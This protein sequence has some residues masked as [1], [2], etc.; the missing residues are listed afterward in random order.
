[1][2]V[3]EGFQDYTVYHYGRYEQGFLDR[4]RRS[5]NENEAAAID[6]IRSRTCNVL[7]VIYSHFYFPTHSNSL[8]D[9]GKLL[10]AVWSA[11]DA[12]GIRSLAWRLAWE[13]GREEALKEQLLVY[14]QEDCLAL[15]RVTEFVFS[16][17]ND[18]SAP[19]EGGPRVASAE[20]IRQEGSYRF[21]KNEFFCP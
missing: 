3:I 5:A 1:V 21:R 18:G 11:D 12:S 16:A 13:S 20:D 2:E 10:G 7:G 8:K 19:P 9:I 15:R 17:C 14:N 6:R 4:M